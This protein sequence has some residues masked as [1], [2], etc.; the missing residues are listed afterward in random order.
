MCLKVILLNHRLCKVIASDKTM[1]G[2]LT[3]NHVQ[4]RTKLLVFQN[5]NQGSFHYGILNKFYKGTYIRQKD[6]KLKLH[7]AGTVYSFLFKS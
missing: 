3:Y 6:K 4:S 2:M 1:A 5:V 7:P